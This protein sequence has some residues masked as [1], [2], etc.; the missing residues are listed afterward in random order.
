MNPGNL[1]P[2]LITAPDPLQP[3]LS[4]LVQKLEPGFDLGDLS[5]SLDRVE[6]DLRD[7][8]KWLDEVWGQGFYWSLIGDDLAIPKAFK[9]AEE[10]GANILL[11]DGF[12]VRELLVLI[13]AL[14]GRM[15]YVAGRAPAPTTTETA[16]RKIFGSGNLKE[17]LTGS[18]LYWGR[19][20]EGVFIENPEDSPRTAKK[21]GMMFFTVYPDAPLHQARKYGAAV[22]QDVSNV[23]G[24]VVKLVE[25]LSR[26]APLVLT[27]DHGYIYLG[28]NP[29]KYMWVPYRRQ[30][31][32]GGEYGGDCIEVDGV[33]VAV[34]RRHTPVS[35][36][37]GAV[38]THG[39][40]SLTESLVPIV[41]V[42]AE[43]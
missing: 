36:R 17:A 43:N 22:V 31:R 5:G 35:R 8:E 26:N 21:T 1:L 27:G 40:V 39:G 7:F 28:D 10:L 34:G 19:K 41:T 14:P 15:E 2:S 16:A 37:S 33:K 6:K 42:E 32:F 12:S 25:E 38:I 11:L 24:Q 23:M 13:K 4:W 3:L 20:W 30:P 18:K 9:A 29:A